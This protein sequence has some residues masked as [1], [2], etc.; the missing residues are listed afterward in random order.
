MAEEINEPVTV[1][2]VSNAAMRTVRPAKML[3]RNRVYR[4]KEIAGKD[5]GTYN[6]RAVHIFAVWDGTTTFQLVL[7]TVTLQWR[8]AAIHS[9]EHPG[10]RPD[11]PVKR[12]LREVLPAG[13]SGE[14]C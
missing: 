6:G 2:L 7:D 5:R 12:P 13:F 3:W 4:F 8:L 1:I 14:G 11:I 9:D 10:A